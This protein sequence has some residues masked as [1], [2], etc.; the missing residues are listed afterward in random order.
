[1]GNDFCPKKEDGQNSNMLFVSYCTYTYDIVACKV[2]DELC[3]IQN[4]DIISMIAL[5]SEL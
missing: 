1:M 2:C 4:R 5:Q 3:A